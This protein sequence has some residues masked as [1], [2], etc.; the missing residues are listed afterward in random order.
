M[1]TGA[2]MEGESKVTTDHEEIR[3]W[4][5]DRGGQPASFRDMEEEGEAGILRVTFEGYGDDAALE[6]ISWGE[7]FKKFEESRLAFLYQDK[8]A[9]G[10]TSR[11]NKFINRDSP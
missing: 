11:F 8:T 5:I 4:I 6:K 3:R 10:E 2:K 9:S 7:F 1:V